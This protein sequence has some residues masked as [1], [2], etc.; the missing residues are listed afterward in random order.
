MRPDSRMAAL[1]APRSFM[2][3]MRTQVLAGVRRPLSSTARKASPWRVEEV[4]PRARM[5][6]YSRTALLPLAKP[7]QTAWQ[8]RGAR[9]G[10]VWRRR[11]RKKLARGQNDVSLP[12]MRLDS[13]TATPPHPSCGLKKDELTKPWVECAG[14]ALRRN[15]LAAGVCE[16]ALVRTSLRP[17][18]AL[19]A[20]LPEEWRNIAKG[21]KR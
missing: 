21:R 7:F 19:H 2:W 12:R 6:L 11:V 17:R 4:R 9:R 20:P 13:R 18:G 1:L 14:G 8:R 5:R 3:R 10:C 15:L 16:V